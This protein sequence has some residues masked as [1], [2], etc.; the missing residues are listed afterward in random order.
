MGDEYPKGKPQ[1]GTP[2]P[3]PPPKFTAAWFR[4]RQDAPVENDRV[5]QILELN[6]L[7]L[8]GTHQ[9]RDLCLEVLALR[10]ERD[11]FAHRL[12]RLDEEIARMVE[13]A[14]REF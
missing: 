4:G 13:L 8:V 9:I 1:E 6:R 2:G 3:L 11:T 12:N 14:R 7:A 10:V 5:R